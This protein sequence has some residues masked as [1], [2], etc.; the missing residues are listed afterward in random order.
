MASPEEMKPKG[1]TV[2]EKKAQK[3]APK[4]KRGQPTSAARLVSSVWVK[5]GWHKPLS[6]EVKAIVQNVKL[7]ADS[8]YMLQIR[9]DRPIESLSLRNGLFWEHR[10]LANQRIV[11][12]PAADHLDFFS[13]EE[14]SFHETIGKICKR[15]S[16]S[17]CRMHYFF[18]NM[19]ERE[20]LLWPVEIDGAWIIIIA[21]IQ[22]K[23]SLVTEK[24]HPGHEFADRAV[25]DLAI[26]DPLPENREDR[27]SLIMRRLPLI[28]TEGCIERSP[29][30]IIRNIDLAHAQSHWETGLIAYAFS[31]EFLRRLKTLDWRRA[32]FGHINEREVLWNDFEE[33]YN[34]DAYRESLMSACAHQTIENSGYNVRLALE[35]PSEE[36][37]FEPN[38]LSHLKAPSVQNPPEEV[39]D[40]RWEIFQNPTHTHGVMIPQY[41][42]SPS[43][44]PT[45]E[46]LSPFTNCP[47]PLM[48]QNSEE[49]ELP[50]AV[51]RN[52]EI[53]P[54][55]P[56]SRLSPELEESDTIDIASDAEQF[57]NST[58][59]EPIDVSTN[60]A[61]VPDIDTEVSN[62]QNAPIAPMEPSQ[63]APRIP[64]L[65]LLNSSATGRTERRSEEDYPLDSRKSPA[66]VAAT[67]AGSLSPQPAT[68]NH[69]GNDSH[70][71]VADIQGSKLQ[72]RLEED[73]MTAHH[74][75]ATSA[76]QAIQSGN[77]ESTQKH[78]LEEDTSDEEM[79]PPK[80]LKYTDEL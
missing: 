6:G 61:Q 21:R 38:L 46:S 77:H 75:L 31:R 18:E 50:N 69:Q 35:V 10:Q 30:V 22:P 34:L 58:H 11:S 36:S 4:P 39:P 55:Q 5:Y 17:E 43:S 23:S 53:S 71:F 13:R 26:V 14:G 42:P 48:Q 12:T 70:M 45:G 32:R 67:P 7:M 72:Q 37:N 78:P 63:L 19:R 49:T 73:E 60:E 68:P 62:F 65:D 27:R 80:R 3:N 47:S 9:R 57:E 25:T 28:L 29:D 40:E 74:M 59:F 33:E 56:V 64:G 2:A 76:V 1:R 41:S 52:G 54:S 8:M 24:S 79:S 51:P 44:S 66:L 20:F 15:V 16:D